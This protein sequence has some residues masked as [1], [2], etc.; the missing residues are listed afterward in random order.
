MT[1]AGMI[2]LARPEGQAAG[3]LL[4]LQDEGRREDRVGEQDHDE[5]AE[6]ADR[7][8]DGLVDDEPQAEPDPDQD[9]RR[10]R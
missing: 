7:G 4:A 5:D 10:R 8:G 1:T 6:R 2:R 9:E 3:R